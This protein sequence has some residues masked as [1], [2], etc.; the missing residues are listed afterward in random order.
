MTMGILNLMMWMIMTMILMMSVMTLMMII[1]LRGLFTDDDDDDLGYD[2][3]HVDGHENDNDYA[4]F[5]PYND[6]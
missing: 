5:D 1:M 2:D 3:I 4:V 6:N